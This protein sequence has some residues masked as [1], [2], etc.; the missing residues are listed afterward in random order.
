MR[1]FSFYCRRPLYNSQYA[2]CTDHRL[3]PWSSV[4]DKAGGCLRAWCK[5]NIVSIGEQNR[6]LPFQRGHLNFI[7]LLMTTFERRFTRE[8]NVL[9][10]LSFDLRIDTID[11][12]KHWYVV[13]WIEILDNHL[14]RHL[15]VE[16]SL[17]EKLS[18]AGFGRIIVDCRPAE[19]TRAPPASQPIF[20]RESQALLEHNSLH[21]RN[22]VWPQCCRMQCCVWLTTYKWCVGSDSPSAE[23]TL[24]VEPQV[25]RWSRGFRF[26]HVDWLKWRKLKLLPCYHI[27]R[28]IRKADRIAGVIHGV[29]MHS[30]PWWESNSKCI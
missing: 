25:K 2:T 18:A 30:I 19:I 11:H 5:M 12:T 24:W 23:I 10:V 27:H 26:T 20:R 28:K 8:S 22:T 7:K 21:N 1:S 6:S 13:G 16:H 3:Q 9:W 4:W 29:C 15:K 14:S 17:A